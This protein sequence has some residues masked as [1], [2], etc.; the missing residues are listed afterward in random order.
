MVS[1]APQVARILVDLRKAR[2]VLAPDRRALEIGCGTGIISLGIAPYAAAVIGIDL[3]PEMVEIA[4]RKAERQGVANVDFRVGDGYSLSFDDA[5]FDT[6]L[7]FNTL[8]VVREPTAL[9]REARRLL[10]Q[11]GY[12]VTATDCYAEPVPLTVRLK[13]AVQRLLHMLGVIPF[14]S[15]F[16]REDLLQLFELNAFE[17]A[18]TDVLHDAPVNYYV[19]VRKA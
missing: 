13:L 7:L 19:L 16:T 2:S 12:L 11:S 17:V 5:S 8:H 18:E 1:N 9:L 10:V 14:M 15:Y 6:V 3:S 4:Q